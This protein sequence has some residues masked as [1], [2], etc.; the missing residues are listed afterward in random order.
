MI[1]HSGHVGQCA[2]G[3]STN[4]RGFPRK[5]ESNLARQFQ[6][7]DTF[8][9]TL[10]NP[11]ECGAAISTSDFGFPISDSRFPTPIQSAISRSISIPMS[12][13]FRFRF[14][15]RF[16]IEFRFRFQFV[17]IFDLGLFLQLDLNFHF[18][19]HFRFYC[20]VCCWICWR[21]CDPILGCITL[22]GRI[23]HW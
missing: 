10:E 1:W 22:L 17:F 13:R 11:I 20:I 16:W 19:F 8:R 12:H 4:N 2:N 14:R 21:C 9:D 6:F 7:R 18:Y 15:F 23:L 5:V 3:N